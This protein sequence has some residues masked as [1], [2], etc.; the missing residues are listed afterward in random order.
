MLHHLPHTHSVSPL[1]L[2]AAL[3]TSACAAPQSEPAP[4]P[5]PPAASASASA[6]AS[7][8]VTPRPYANPSA[9]IAAEIAFA[10]LA[11]E[12][13]QWTAFRETVA[14]NGMMFVPL[15]VNAPE[16]LKD[17]ADPP[18]AVKWQAHRVW[19]SCDGS[20]GATHGA[21]QGPDGSTGYFITVWLRQPDG[22]YKWVLDHGAPTATPP[23]AGEMIDGRVASCEGK[24]SAPI[25]AP[26]VGEDMRTGLAR[27]QSLQWV[28]TVHGDQ[29]RTIEIRLWNGKGFET[30]HRDFVTAEQA[31]AG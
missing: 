13:G 10:R 3:L 27:D 31:K 23:V 18:K 21:W 22:K 16:W 6:S 2:A 1:I 9:L 25:S 15:R 26:A 28:S 17:R 29:S 20:A 14:P 5:A 4:P 7:A 19:M 12:K 11:Q 24:A 30:V 8:R